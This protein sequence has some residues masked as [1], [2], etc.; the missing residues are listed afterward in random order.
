MLGERYL[1][2]RIA[3]K[4]SDYMRRAALGQDPLDSLTPRQ[5]EM[6]QLVVQGYSNKDIA[7]HLDVSVK[8]VEAHRAQIMETLG[9]KD[10]PGL[11]RFG[12]RNGLISAEH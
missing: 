6:L 10:V 9:L 11:V 8:T 4:V 5:R 12:I 7:S 3:P 2:S 1:D